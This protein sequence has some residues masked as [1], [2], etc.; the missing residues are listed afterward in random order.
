M[1]SS[2]QGVFQ[3][4]GEPPAAVQALCLAARG[5]SPGS[6]KMMAF[7]QAY[8]LSSIW[9]SRRGFTNSSKILVATRAISSSG[10]CIGMMKSFPGK[11]RGVPRQVLALA[12]LSSS[13]SL[14]VPVLFAAVSSLQLYNLI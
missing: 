3:D 14:I 2:F 13:S 1:Q 4:F 9:M 5:I 11:T 10:Q 6:K 8:S 7:R 12:L